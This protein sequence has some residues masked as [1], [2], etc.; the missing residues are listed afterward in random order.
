[1]NI[2]EYMTYVNRRF[3]EVMY[4]ERVP[5]AY[6]CA[7]CRG[8]LGFLKGSFTS[9]ETKRS[10]QAHQED[11]WEIEMVELVFSGILVCK[12]CGENYTVSG[13]GAVEEDF[14]EEY[15]HHICEYFTPKYFYPE[16][17]LF[18]IAPKT[19]E[20]IKKIIESSFS[21]AWSD[22]SAAANK[23]R[24]ALELIVENLVPDASPKDS[25]GLKIQKIPDEQVQIRKMIN[26]IKWLGNEASHTSRLKECDLAFAYEVMDS[27]LNDLY[28]DNA[29][30]E[31]LLKHVD[32]VNENKGSLVRE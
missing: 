10:A 32:R 7:C 3:I 31:S 20:N 26:A 11:W 27:V 1:M 25:L 4:E 18:K 9:Q 17:H 19:P 14:D 5:D 15:G 29:K 8:G 2:D 6:K 22:F 30:R 13:V 16:I 28:P 23:L 12:S 24:I 21:L